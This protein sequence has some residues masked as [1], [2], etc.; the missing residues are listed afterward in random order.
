MPP[1]VF[2]VCWNP[3]E[4][5]S[6]ASEGMDLSVRVR[7]SRQKESKLPSFT[8]FMLEAGVAQ[9]KGISSLLKDPVQTWVFTLQII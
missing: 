4:A 1:V 8:S 3:E 5:G 7:A 6:N 9:I 2:S